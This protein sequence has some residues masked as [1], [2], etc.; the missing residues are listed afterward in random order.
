M[1][2]RSLM[3]RTTV[4]AFETS[5]VVYDVLFLALTEGADTVLITDDGKL[6]QTLEDTPSVGEAPI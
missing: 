1:R 2:L 5:A 6:L 3:P 4:I